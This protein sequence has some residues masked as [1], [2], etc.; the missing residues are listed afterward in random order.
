MI[1]ER[2]KKVGWI[3]ELLPDVP[4]V[5]KCLRGLAVGIN[6]Y[7]VLRSFFR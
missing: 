3:G 5:V 2:G 1:F 4:W 6:V 7:V